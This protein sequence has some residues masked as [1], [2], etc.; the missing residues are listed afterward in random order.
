[1]DIDDIVKY[2][3][4]YLG[5]PK[6][7]PAFKKA[8]KQLVEALPDRSLGGMIR[9]EEKRDPVTPE[10]ALERQELEEM[11]R[12]VV[13]DILTV[14]IANALQNKSLGYAV[15]KT[16]AVA[17]TGQYTRRYQTVSGNRNRDYQRTSGKYQQYSGTT[18]SPYRNG[19]KKKRR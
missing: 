12:N 7:N 5:K 17:R 4:K 18:T 2:R 8:G 6:V 11:I 1:M 16:S 14:G 15:K 19:Q 3:N 10:E 13:L 9:D